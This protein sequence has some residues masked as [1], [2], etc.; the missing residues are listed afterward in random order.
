MQPGLCRQLPAHHIPCVRQ[1]LHLH[2]AGTQLP[3]QT[4]DGGQGGTWG[5]SLQVGQAAPSPSC[6]GVQRRPRCPRHGLCHTA[7]ALAPSRGDVRVLQ[8]ID[9]YFPWALNEWR[10][11]RVSGADYSKRDKIL[12]KLFELNASSSLL[13]AKE[14]GLKEKKKKGVEIHCLVFP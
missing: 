10:E 13:F 9:F 11:K 3:Q 6:C 14:N 5:H 2:I 8:I 7:G 12:K 1:Q 4:W